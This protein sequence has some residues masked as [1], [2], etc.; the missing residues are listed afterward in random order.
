MRGG[1]PGVLQFVE[2]VCSDAGRAAGCPDVDPRLVNGRRSQTVG[3]DC[4]A[5]S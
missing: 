3:R 2:W 5:C 1:P 4:L